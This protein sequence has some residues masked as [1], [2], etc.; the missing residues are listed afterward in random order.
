MPGGFIESMTMGEKAGA[1]MAY[2]TILQF[3]RLIACIVSIPLAFQFLTGT[4]VGTAGGAV[5]GAAPDGL[6]ARDWAILVASGAAGA[7]LGHVLRLPAGILMGPFLVS[8]AAHLAGWVTAGPPGW[9]I[10]VTQLVIGTSLG[11]RFAGRSPRVLLTGTR[12]A[13]VNVAAMLALSAL[14]ALLL[15]GPVGQPFAAV[16]IAFAPGGVAEMA[17][18]AVSLQI[19]VVY[20]TVHHLIRILLAVFVARLLAPRVLGSENVLDSDD[21]R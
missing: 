10:E 3:L 17:L 8:G 20:V 11:A 16:F 13:L 4:A 19:G 1:D 14:F 21:P 5:I 2:V 6:T 12:L 18:V 9:L 15:S 7:A